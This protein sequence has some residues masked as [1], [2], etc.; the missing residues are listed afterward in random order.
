MFIHSANAFPT[1][2]A[3]FAQLIVYLTKYASPSWFSLFFLLFNLPFFLLFW[4]HLGR[5]FIFYTAIWLGFQ[6]IWGQTIMRIHSFSIGN[7]FNFHL[8]PHTHSYDSAGRII[9]AIYGT[10]FAGV[11]MGLALLAGGSTGGTDFIAYYLYLKHKKSI[12]FNDILLGLST[13]FIAMI[14]RYIVGKPIE[15]SIFTLFFGVTMCITLIYIII[16]API[17]NTIYP[18]HKKI[19]VK[20]STKKGKEIVDE[21]VKI[22]FHHGYMVATEKSGFSGQKLDIITSIMFYMEASSFINMIKK[23]DPDAWISITLVHDVVGNFQEKLLM[24]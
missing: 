21:L 13:A 16:T 12:G 22:K 3:A 5:K 15:K 19:S 6:L 20:I 18:R 2:V 14:I 8:D 9:Y 11:S 10:I 24:K 4:K 7:P 17:V 23:I 1:G